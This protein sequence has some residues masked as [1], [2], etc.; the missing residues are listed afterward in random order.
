MTHVPQALSVTEVSLGS[1]VAPKVLLEGIW[2]KVCEV[3]REKQECL[4]WKKSAINHLQACGPNSSCTF[5]F[6]VAVSGIDSI[7]ISQ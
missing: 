5:F 1:A 3:D 2:K 7:Y 4:G 6:Q